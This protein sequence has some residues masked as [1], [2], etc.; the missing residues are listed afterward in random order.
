MLKLIPLKIL[1]PL[2]L[3]VG[4]ASYFI[5]KKKSKKDVVKDASLTEDLNP[6]ERRAMNVAM[7]LISAL[8]TEGFWSW[9]ED[10]NKVVELLNE[11]SDIIPLIEQQYARLTKKS[12]SL[13][14]D[15]SKYL[16]ADDIAK[17]KTP[18]ITS[19]ITSGHIQNKSIAMYDS[20]ESVRDNIITERPQAIKHQDFGEKLFFQKRNA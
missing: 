14:K 6:N 15:I 1:I 5:F 11:N 9:T 20:P 19:K 2:A 12:R 3:S 16:S 7:Q 4:V 8:G 13:F 10:E 18:L 17:I